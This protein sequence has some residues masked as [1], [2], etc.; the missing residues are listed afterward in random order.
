M[1]AIECSVETVT[2]NLRFPSRGSYEDRRPD[3]GRRVAQTRLRSVLRVRPD[4]QDSSPAT[5]HRLES[6]PHSPL[7]PPEGA[8]SVADGDIRRLAWDLEDELQRAA[9]NGEDDDQ[10]EALRSGLAEIS[11]L[12]DAVMREIARIQGRVRRLESRPVITVDYREGL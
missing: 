2:G 4:V 3:G 6:L 5:L 9:H 1:A 10:D 8:L 12:L 7:A 11:D